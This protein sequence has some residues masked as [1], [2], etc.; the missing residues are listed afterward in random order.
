MLTLGLKSLTHGKIQRLLY[1]K[2]AVVRGFA[3]FRKEMARIRVTAASQPLRKAGL[4]A[5][6]AAMAESSEANHGEGEEDDECVDDE[7][8]EDEDENV[9]EDEDDEV[10]ENGSYEYSESSS[11]RSSSDEEEDSVSSQDVVSEQDVEHCEK[12]KHEIRLWKK[13][14]E[15]PKM[16][17][18]YLRQELNGGKPVHRID[19][20]LNS[21][22]E[23]GLVKDS[24]EDVRALC[25][26]CYRWVKETRKELPEKTCINY[27]SSKDLVQQVDAAAHGADR[28]VSLLVTAAEKR[29]VV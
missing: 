27:K 17:E 22:T 13:C 24:P 8:E 28:E 9:D 19:Q 20:F 16:F 5:A 25:G 26:V 23:I 3:S 1:Q 15:S 11:E 18:N 10:E 12:T 21:L 4:A 2:V 7:E 14:Y 6:A 29:V